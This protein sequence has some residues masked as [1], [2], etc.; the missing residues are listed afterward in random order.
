MCFSASASFG[1]GAVLLAMG[2]TSLKKCSKPSQILFASI[3]LFFALQQITEG[4][5]WVSLLH[6]SFALC[7]WPA[8]YLFLL[9]AQIIWPVWVPLSI[10]LLEKDP[11]RKKWLNMALG[12]GLLVSVYLAFRMVTQH[13]GASIIGWHVVYDI[14]EP[15]PVLHSSTVLYFI[16][17]VAPSFISSVK[18]MW[19]FGISA[20]L[21]Y[22]ISYIF[23]E[24]YLISVWCF[25][26]AIM[27]SAVI[28]IM[29]DLYKNVLEDNNAP[30]PSVESDGGK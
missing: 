16:A 26:A 3:P 20:T 2:V 23:F 24:H 28:T 27:S 6:P 15:D 8:T 10:R 11:N 12:T 29:F 13:V 7:R 25:L 18:K 17:T 5:L 14:G 22:I 9:F 30:K 19:I 4:F 1:A 21:A